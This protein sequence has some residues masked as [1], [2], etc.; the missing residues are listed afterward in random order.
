MK[1]WSS[2]AFVSGVFLI[3]CGQ[4]KPEGPAP[5]ASTS[6]SSVPEK[7]S[8]KRKT[9]PA[10]LRLADEKDCLAGKAE[11]CRRMANRYQGYGHFAGCGLERPDGDIAYGRMVENMP[12][13]LKRIVDDF[14]AD[15]KEFISW[16]GKACDL[17]DAQACT[18]E[19][20]ART[21][22][23]PSDTND[24]QTSALLE[25][26]QASALAGFIE[27][28]NPDKYEKYAKQ[29]DLCWAE[30][31]TSCWNLTN[32]LLTLE[33][34]AKRPELTPE[35]VAK[36][37]AIG[38]RTLDFEALFMML[39]KFGHTLEALAPL[40]THAS[41]TLLQACVEGGCVCGEA[42]KS[43][44][45][46]D[47]RVPD[48]ARWGC[49]NGEASGC[50][51]LGKLHEEGRNVEKD[52]TFARSLYEAACP[53]RRSSLSYRWGEF[54]PAACVRLA[55]MAEGG[56][57]P[58]KDRERAAYYMQSVCQ[59]PGIE[60]DHSYC[61]KRAKYWISGIFTTSCTDPNS[62]WCLTNVKEA[63]LYMNGRKEGPSNGKEC[64]RP[65]VKALCDALQPEYEALKKPA[66]KKK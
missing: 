32:T 20:F 19:G 28:T 40:K 34:D 30:A 27:V 56:A 37:Q 5:V 13:R 42:A 4:T 46:D 64:E 17:K 9:T 54:E 45:L 33:Q 12:V 55:E 7:P 16:I 48:L 62:E 66:G 3:G 61:L 24:L 26:V 49:E 53:G 44:P 59:S 21:G 57:N 63:A 60:R 2:F 22:R 11:A 25:N 15:Q 23:M 52:E 6:A 51:V 47:P 31:S 35:F 65:S 50:Y 58:P 29:R 39:D 38:E 1:M 14:D 10:A 18:I 41:K 36:L 8:V 43:L